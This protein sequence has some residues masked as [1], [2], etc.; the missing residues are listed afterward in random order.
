[1]TGEL[2]G[3]A[4]AA[5]LLGVTPAGV[6]WLVAHERLQPVD[7]T[8]A[9]YVFDRDAVLAAAKR[10]VDAAAGRARTRDAVR[11]AIGRSGARKARRQGITT[12]TTTRE[13]NRA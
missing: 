6:R 8:S 4:Q 12:T 2:I 1:M 11:G 9:G 7:R 3:T 13:D 5:E 10:R